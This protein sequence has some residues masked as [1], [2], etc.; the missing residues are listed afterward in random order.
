MVFTEEEVTIA[1]NSFNNDLLVGKG[2]FGRVYKGTIRHVCVAI[3]QLTSVS[4][5]I[6]CTDEYTCRGFL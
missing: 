6:I 1:T 3:K 4:M 5:H 2:G